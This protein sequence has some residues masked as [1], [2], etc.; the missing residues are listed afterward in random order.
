MRWAGQQ[1]QLEAHFTDMY[2]LKLGDCKLA[3][4]LQNNASQ[5]GL[6]DTVKSVQF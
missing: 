4:K 6:S 5:L 1:V 3:A 2:S